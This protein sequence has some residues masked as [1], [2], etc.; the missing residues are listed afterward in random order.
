VHRILATDDP[1]TLD[2]L[3]DHL[4]EREAAPPG[5]LLALLRGPGRAA[6]DVAGHL[7]P[8]QARALWQL[9]LDLSPDMRGGYQPLGRRRA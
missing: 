4:L 3:G 2:V 9:V 8:H 7:D 5:P 6:A 1:A